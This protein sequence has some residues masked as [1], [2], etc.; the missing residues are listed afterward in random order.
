MYPVSISFLR[1]AVYF[2]RLYF[3]TFFHQIDQKEA[4][5]WWEHVPSAS[6][7]ADGSS[8]TSH[9]DAL[10]RTLGV[11]LVYVV[12]SQFMLDIMRMSPVEV[13][14]VIGKRVALSV[15]ITPWQRATRRIRYSP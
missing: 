12:F 15:V 10:V 5:T 2:M 1:I 8:R 13:F 3:R 4:L 9:R 7:A 6:N 14:D 11:P